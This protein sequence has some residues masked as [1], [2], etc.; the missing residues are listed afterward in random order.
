MVGLQ[1]ARSSA[2]RAHRIVALVGLLLHE[3]DSE[4][5]VFGQLLG[6][7]ALPVNAAS[8]NQSTRAKEL[9]YWAAEREVCSAV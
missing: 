2:F 9:T 1:R 3:P 6:D 5:E 7:V 8:L 4:N